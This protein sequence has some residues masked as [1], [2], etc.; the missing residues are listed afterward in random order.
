MEASGASPDR[1]TLPLVLKACTRLRDVKLGKRIHSDISGTDLI[2]NVRVRTALI[3]FY[4][5]C[6]LLDDAYELF[7]E[8]T[9]GD[10]AYWN[11][12]ISGHVKNFRYKDSIFLFSRMRRAGFDPNSVTLVSLLSACTKLSN[13]RLG[14]EIH[15]YCLRRGFFES[16]PHVGTSLIGFYSGFD[17]GGVDE[18]L[19]AFV[20]MLVD[21]VA[22]DSVTLLA[23]LQSCVEFGCLELGKQIHQLAVKIIKFGF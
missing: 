13:L 1:L 20:Q 2:E 5:K 12:M 15:C 3:D 11:A 19:E 18:A 10:L 16:E 14:K 8:M 17:V 23:A 9:Q 7:E 4:C 22:P 21:N 6:G